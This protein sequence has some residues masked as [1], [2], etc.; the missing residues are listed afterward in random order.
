[1]P[2]ESVPSWVRIACWVVAAAR[3]GTGESTG[4]SGSG[5]ARMSR[6]APSAVVAPKSCHSGCCWRFFQDGI[7]FG[8]I[9]RRWVRACSLP[10]NDMPVG[11]VT[12][13]IALSAR[14]L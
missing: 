3:I 1:M 6:R 2:R 13:L 5:V 11:R 7:M 14:L 10:Y 8:G 9:T 12:A 4:W